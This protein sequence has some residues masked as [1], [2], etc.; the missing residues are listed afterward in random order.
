MRILLIAGVNLRRTLRDRTAAFFLFIFPMMMVLIMG[1][2]FGGSATPKVAVVAAGDG[3]LA[4]AL[5][6]QLRTA[7][8]LAVHPATDAASATAAVERGELD[9]VVLLPADYDTR[10]RDGATATVQYVARPGLQSQQVQTIVSAVVGREAARLRAARFVATEGGLGFDSGLARTD[11]VAALVP[12]LTVSVRTTGEAIFP[13]TLGRFD[14]G[15]GAQLILFVFLTALTTSATLIESRRFGVSRRMV[16]TPTPVGAI[17]LGEAAGR[18]AVAATQALV[19]MIGSALVFGVDWGDP[20]GAAALVTAFTAVASGAGLLLGAT[21]RT[22]QQSLGVGLLAGLGLAA[23]GGSMLP[24][25]LF[26][27]TMRTVAHLTPHAWAADGFAELV[28]RGGGLV[29]VLPQVGVLLAIAAALL[30]GAAWRLHRT[31][32]T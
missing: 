27:P 19:I 5:V 14:Y 20:L 9:A 21:A 16:S 23:L 2:V 25:E 28:R 18:M 12:A 15:A 17:V 6:S 4:A 11:A 1:V 30:T 22:A 29:D 7:D 26:S 8:G 24:L 13:A 32:S 3:P 31:L 10:V